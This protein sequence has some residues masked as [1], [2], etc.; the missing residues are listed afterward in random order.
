VPKIRL[1]GVA[2]GVIGELH[3]RWVQKYE[4]GTAPVVFELD[5]PAPA[6]DA[7]PAYAEVSRFRPVVRDLAWWCRRPGVLAP[8][9][10]AFGHAAP[11]IVRDVAVR[12]VSPEKGSTRRRKKPCVPDSYARYSTDSRRCGSGCGD[13]HLLAYLQLAT[14]CVLAC[15]NREKNDADQGGTRRSFVRKSRPQQ[16]RSQRHGRGF[17]RR[18]AN[19]LERGDGVKLSGFGNFQLRDKP[20]RPGRNP[21]PAKKSRSPPVASSPSTPARS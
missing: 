3:P 18:G 9:W 5:L 14:S 8:C 19:A 15:L 21:R 13:R 4:L 2:V 1:D 10:M 7:I 20:Q 12:C 11:A 16:A 17:L 6:G